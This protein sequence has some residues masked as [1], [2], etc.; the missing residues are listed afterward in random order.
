MSSED[1]HRCPVCGAE[2]PPL[3]WQARGPIAGALR[4]DDLL[5]EA[6]RCPECG[7]C[8]ER[9]PSEPWKVAGQAK[10]GARPTTPDSSGGPTM[11]GQRDGQ[12]KI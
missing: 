5:K 7:S 12:H 4:S 2:V 1:P 10:S 3:S 9:A 11:T 8:L 6:R